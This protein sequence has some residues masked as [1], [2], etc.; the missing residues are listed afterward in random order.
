MS[1]DIYKLL[2]L[3]KDKIVKIVPNPS[4]GIGPIICDTYCQLEVKY[5]SNRKVFN[6]S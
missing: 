5:N 1:D 2:T 4:K 3:N 6:E